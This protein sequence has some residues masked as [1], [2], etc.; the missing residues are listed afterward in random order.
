MKIISLNVRGLN[1][2]KK[3]KIVFQYLDKANCDFAFL[4]ETYSSSKEET[5]WLQEWGGTGYF[6]HGTKHSCGVAILIKNNYN[7]EIIDSVLDNCGRYI[8]LK[9]KVGE[10]YFNLINVYSPNKES[11]KAKFIARLIQILESNNITNADNNILAGDWNIT[12]EA[13]DK[14]GGA[15]FHKSIAANEID[16]MREIYDLIDIWRLRNRNK[17]RYTWRQK[18]PRVHCRLDYF[19]ISNHISDFICSNQILSS[20]LSDHS[21]VEIS[22][23]FLDT[24]KLGSGHWK[25]NVSLLNDEGY[26]KLVREHINK[27]KEQYNL[28]N[29]NLKWELI[30]YETKKLSIEYS[31]KRRKEQNNKKKE[32]EEELD[33]LENQEFENKESIFNRIEIIKEELKLIYNKEAQGAI[34]RSRTQWVEEGEK[35]TAYFFNLEKS[36]AI[37]KNI[38]KIKDNNK[39]I[40]DQESILIYIEN[41]YKNLYKN[42]A[43]ETNSNLFNQPEIVKLDDNDQGKCDGLIS[44]EE[45]TLVLDK[46]SKNK[47]PGN[48]GL[49]IEFYREFWDDVGETMID[50]FN[51]S[52]EHELLSTSQRQSIITL[53]EKPGKD[54]LFL[55]NWRP[56]S[57][58]NVDYKI[59][60]KC[61]SQRIQK[62]IPK[63]VDNSQTGFIKGRSIFDNLRTILDILE[64]TDLN[65]KSG[66]LISID[67]EKAFD[68]LSWEY[69]FKV[70]KTFNFG[71]EF[72]KWIQICYTDISSCVVN[73][74]QASP[75]FKI[76]KGVRQGDPLSPYLFILATE[77]M[78]IYIR[79]NENIRGLMYGNSE[80]KLVAYADDTTIFVK[81]Q[82]D[83]KH[84]FSFLNK[85]EKYS[86]LKMNKHKTE[87]MWLGIS[88]NSTYKPLGIKWSS[89]IKILGVFISYD[90]NIMYKYNFDN[91]MQKIKNSLNIWKKRDLTIYGKTLIIKTFALS[92]ILHISTV[93]HVPDEIVKAIK[94]MVF[95]FLWQGKT[96]KV[97]QNVVIQDY[98]FG[99]CKMLDIDETLKVQKLKWIKWYFQREELHWKKTMREIIGAENLDIFLKSNFEIPKRV[100]QNI[101]YYELL[102]TWRNMKYRH[103]LTKEDV[104]NQY[105]WYNSKIRI[106]NK[107]VYNAS[108]IKR[109]FIQIKDIVKHDRQFK[110]IQEISIDDGLKMVYIGIVNAIPLEWKIL[111]QC[112]DE[113]RLSSDC[114]ISIDNKAKNIVDV[115][116]KQIYNDLILQKC[117]QSASCAKLG[118]KFQIADEE[119]AEYFVLLHKSGVPNKV[120]ELQYKIF[121]SY[122]ATNKLLYKMNIRPSPRCNFCFLYSQD[123]EHLIFECMVVK[124]FWFRV[125]E[126]LS[127]Q[128]EIEKTFCLKDVMIG[129]LTDSSLLN[130]VVLYSKYYIL[131]CKYQDNMP[132]IEQ[133]IEYVNVYLNN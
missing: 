56:I 19:L 32:L 83:A 7:V 73:Y 51:Y 75:Y 91:K 64:E 4:Q 72:V 108:F 43:I 70:L 81:D 22:L 36:N 53:L 15:E 71:S 59:L 66:C 79:N 31:K 40:S 54:R 119:W 129:C 1:N 97:K 115:T 11:D 130:K 62:V 85:F 112:D 114:L 58:L 12:L 67:F 128:Y 39:E 5:S 33:Y 93:L 105:L 30:K 17:R 23:K 125:R 118:T 122:V 2:S 74:K 96:H 27:W 88:K 89:V 127:R 37:K 21:P 63:L 38:R 109:N 116:I 76:E 52:F 55:K 124:N 131:K 48:D 65:D 98:Q 14:M 113:C 78:S 24:P 34:I 84:I 50:S 10:L 121:H 100:K 94:T 6:A 120:K 42:D 99:G 61:L 102:K 95:T 3:R 107:T 13:Q 110:S 9:I 86:G 18:S 111:L 104:L 80:I 46:F 26:V 132:N 126:W 29:C 123:I 16:D 133:F 82:N 49:P 45:C 44:I 90:K 69:L 8:I 77:I 106:Q 101:F 92:Q 68:S 25:L 60:T 28:E 47:T 20:V 35:S 117:E 87:A 103:I 57:L 41:Y